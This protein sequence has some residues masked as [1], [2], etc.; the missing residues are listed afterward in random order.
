MISRSSH[1]SFATFVR[2]FNDKCF[3]L[4]VP[5]RGP[6]DGFPKSNELPQPETRFCRADVWD[7][8]LRQ[9]AL[10][11]LLPQPDGKRRV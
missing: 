8:S 3:F 2:T 11:W 5:I 1:S 7:V 6:A 4:A 10:N 9:S